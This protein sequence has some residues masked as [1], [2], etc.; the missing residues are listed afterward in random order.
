M[1]VAGHDGGVSLNR[2]LRGEDPT[3]SGIEERIV[4]HRHDRGCDGVKGWPTSVKNCLAGV[5]SVP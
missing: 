1:S 4:L 3:P 2:P 5:E